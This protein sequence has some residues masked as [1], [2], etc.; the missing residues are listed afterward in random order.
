MEEREDEP[1][2][3]FDPRDGSDPFEALLDPNAAASAPVE[4]DAEQRL[5]EAQRRQRSADLARRLAEEQRHQAELDERDRKR[6]RRER[7]S[8]GLPRVAAGVV[9][10]AFVVGG[11]WI[12]GAFESAGS[13][14][15]LAP[16][17][18]ANP[19]VP[20]PG[21][22]STGERLVELPPEPAGDGPFEFLST[23]D[24]GSPITYDPC[25]PIAW[26]Y[27]STGAPPGSEQLVFEAVELT[28]AASGLAFEYEGPT[29]E[30]WDK[31]R[32]PFQSDRYGD[33]WAPVLIAWSN[34]QDVPGLGGYI[35][36]LGGSQVWDPGTG[37]GPVYVTGS[38]VL[39]AADLGQFPLEVPE[40]AAAVRATIQHELGH[41]VGLDH[42][43]DPQQI[44][45]TEG[46]EQATIDWG[47]GD[48]RGLRILGDGECRPDI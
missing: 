3:G 17:A 38:L 30:T 47:Y 48:L 29:T 19:D 5:R 11:L 43:A 2:H 12:T 45:N 10:V 32:D 36:G 7:R 14:Q 21:R 22:G 39:D 34:E 9:L 23:S 46:S 20:T 24:D 6:G 1:V 33:R 13:D 37:E 4:P 28:A 31:D 18:P 16:T 35:A 26:V 8:R 27:N 25:R 15:A 41:V 42:V 44:M 40:A